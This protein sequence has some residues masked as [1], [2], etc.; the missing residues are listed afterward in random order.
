MPDD[1]PDWDAVMAAHPTW[2]HVMAAHPTWDHL[3]AAHSGPDPQ[4]Q[5]TVTEEEK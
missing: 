1:Q 3:I 4:C 2:D 5:P